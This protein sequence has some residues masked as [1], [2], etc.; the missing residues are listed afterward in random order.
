MIMM[1]IGDNARVKKNTTEINNLLP[2]AGLCAQMLPSGI[3]IAFR[4]GFQRSDR[5]V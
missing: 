2:F 3:V 5:D 4:V 1:K